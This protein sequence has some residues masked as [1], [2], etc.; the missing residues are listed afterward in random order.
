[1]N[2][3]G[4]ADDGPTLTALRSYRDNYMANV[5]EM[6]PFIAEYYVVAPKI[7]EAMGEDNPY[8]AWIEEQVDISVSK[9]KAGDMDGTFETY[10]NMVET[11]KNTFNVSA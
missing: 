6:R 9:I 5:P 11:L 3:R 8:W 2:R 7:I 1:M 10:K 4:E